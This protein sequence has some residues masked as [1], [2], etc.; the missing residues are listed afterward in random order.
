MT[1]NDVKTGL[2]N[3]W[4]GVK[5]VSGNLWNG[6]KQVPVIGSVAKG[7]E[8]IV[9]GVGY[10]IENVGSGV[11]N[12]YNSLY[13]VNGSAS[14]VEP[15]LSPEGSTGGL[16]L[17]KVEDIQKNNQ[18]AQQV[19]AREQWNASQSSADKAMKFSADQAQINREWQ[20]QMSN[21]A[22]QRAVQD[23][24]KA[25][26]NPMLAFSQGGA[27]TPSGSAPSGNSA[28]MSKANVDDD[29]L[30]DILTTYLDNQTAMQVSQSRG[31][32][33]LLGSLFK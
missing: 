3:L 2:G 9:N 6:V 32:F 28:S 10:A 13:G 12:L 24:R 7:V 16:D 27:S 4:N 11:K 21:T 20:E 19:I 29:T 25:G 30:R 15:S 8:G 18:I 17:D 33:N 31:L 22:Y 5:Q 14:T 26:I 23:M 1:W